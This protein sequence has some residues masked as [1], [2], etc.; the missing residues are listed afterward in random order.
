MNRK[1]LKKLIKGQVLKEYIIMSILGCS[2][3][4]I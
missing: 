4:L 1:Q 3:S 2:K